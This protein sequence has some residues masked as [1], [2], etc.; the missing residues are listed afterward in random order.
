MLHVS[1]AALTTHAIVRRPEDSTSGYEL[2]PSDLGGWRQRRQPFAER[3][4]AA[5][6][7]KA[8]SDVK[9]LHMIGNAHIDPVWLWQWPEGYQEVRATFQSAVERLDEFP[10]YIFTCDSS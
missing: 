5:R 2:G 6:E 8:A 3:R 4:S 1:G 7:R 10:E 9:K